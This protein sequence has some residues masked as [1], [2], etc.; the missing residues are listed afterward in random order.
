MRK[1]ICMLLAVMILLASTAALGEHQALPQNISVGDVLAFGHYEQDNN[2]DNGPEPIEWIVLDV[3]DGKAL[4]LSRYGLVRFCF[5]LNHNRRATKQ[6]TLHLISPISI[7][8]ASKSQNQ[9]KQD[10]VFELRH[11]IL[12]KK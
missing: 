11:S 1:L 7:N 2:P 9:N 3:Q 6:D 4:L 10:D 8:T 5:F 12:L